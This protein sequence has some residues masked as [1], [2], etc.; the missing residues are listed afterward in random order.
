MGT[1]TYCRLGM[2]LST[3]KNRVMLVSK[4]GEFWSMLAHH[5]PLL[6]FNY[7]FTPV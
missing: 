7:A 2:L 6:G 3:L 4:G 1:L 5:R